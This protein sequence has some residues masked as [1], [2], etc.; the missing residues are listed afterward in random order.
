MAEEVKVQLDWEEGLRFN[1]KGDKSGIALKVDSPSQPACVGPSPMELLLMGV[2]GCTAMDVVSILQKMRQPLKRFSLE[3][4]GKRADTNPKYYQE[5]IL[6][7]HLWG[8]GLDRQKVE[9]AVKLSHETYCSAMASLRP[10]C[11]VESQ[12]ELH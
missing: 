9:K 1:V 5:I 3:V 4:V 10:D 8:E 7:Y 11:R 12:I 2:A 6:V